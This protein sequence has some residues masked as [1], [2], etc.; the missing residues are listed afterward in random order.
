MSLKKNY[1]RFKEKRHG[2]QSLA[3][4]KDILLEKMEKLIEAQSGG[5]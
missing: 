2:A 1:Y 5:K 4:V 3:S